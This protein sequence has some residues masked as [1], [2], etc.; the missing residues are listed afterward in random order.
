MS[1]QEDQHPETVPETSPVIMEDEARQVSDQ[2]DVKLETDPEIS[3][4]MMK[5]EATQISDQENVQLE[6]VQETSQI[7]MEDEATQ[8]SEQEDAQLEI[9]QKENKKPDL[10]EMME[11]LGDQ[12]KALDE[13]DEQQDT[14]ESL[15]TKNQMLEYTNTGL[16][17]Q[18]TREKDKFSSLQKQLEQFE[19]N[20]ES[21]NENLTEELITMSRRL[22]KCHG[23]HVD[24]N[25]RDKLFTLTRLLT[26]EWKPSEV[27]VD[28][29]SASSGSEYEIEEAPLLSDN[30]KPPKPFTTFELPQRKDIMLDELKTNDMSTLLESSRAILKDEATWMTEPEEAQLDVLQKEIERLENNVP[31]KKGWCCG[32]FK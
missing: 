26:K 25:L 31:T 3:K 11:Q 22:G 13:M 12:K 24:D 14:I 29:K 28:Q 30:L 21:E 16:I 32:L 8:M 23:A 20:S 19:S 5:D 18:L 17:M 4:V 1:D 15:T 27:I 10:K 7:I 6:E 2:E 9:I